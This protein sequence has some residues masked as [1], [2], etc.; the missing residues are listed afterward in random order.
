MVTLLLLRNQNTA[1]HRELG[2][3]AKSPSLF[4]LL[5]RG[6]EDVAHGS[7]RKQPAGLLMASCWTLVQSLGNR[8][9]W[10]AVYL[11]PALSV[12]ECPS[13]G[14]AV[15]RLHEC[16]TVSGKPCMDQTQ[17]PW[18]SDNF[19]YNPE[20]LH[21]ITLSQA[22]LLLLNYPVTRLRGDGFFIM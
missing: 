16:I 15:P 21:W 13:P 12:N 20:Q 11:L 2:T 8:R 22:Y 10:S 17:S 4:L 5:Y 1:Q 6:Q 9:P 18:K 3:R 14:S 7:T 19:S